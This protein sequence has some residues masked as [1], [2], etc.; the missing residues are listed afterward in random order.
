LLLH[1]Q[2]KKNKIVLAT[3]ITIKIATLKQFYFCFI[4]V[5]QITKIKQFCFIF[6]LL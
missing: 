5:M 6:I 2:L 4:A 1:P 3:L